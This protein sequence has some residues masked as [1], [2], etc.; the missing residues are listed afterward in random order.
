MP[1]PSS[2]GIQIKGLT[3]VY[4]RVK[5]V[6]R[7][8]LTVQD[9]EFLTI[10]GPNG[11]G[12][13]TLLGLIAGLIRPTTGSVLLD[14]FDMVMDRDRAI[15]RKI[16]VL[17]YHTYLYD[18]LTV[19]ENLRFYGT[20]YDVD[21]LDQRVHAALE[22]VGLAGRAQ[23]VTRTLSR[24]M[25]QRLALARAILHDPPI[26]LLDEPYAGLDQNAI[27]MLQALLTQG[28]RTVLLVTHDLERG[29]AVADRI[30]IMVRGRLVY[31]LPSDGLS[32][33][34]FEALYRQH[35]T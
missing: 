1:D 14:G 8:D 31:E 32:L 28:A 10:V 33:Q 16:G 3:K 18:D 29:L 7:L 30:A 12:K 24:G 9:G 25:R 22:S 13:T 34:D 21:R 15:G 35:A 19:T 17:S 23:S 6:N 20:L 27:A 26:L 5:A 11:A 2:H 4:G